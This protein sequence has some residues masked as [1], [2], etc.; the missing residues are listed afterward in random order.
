MKRLTD[1]IKGIFGSGAEVTKDIKITNLV[2]IEKYDAG[3]NGN[4]LVSQDDDL[5]IAYAERSKGLIFDKAP[6]TVKPD[7][8]T[9]YI[10]PNDQ[11]AMKFLKQHCDKTTYAVMEICPMII[12]VSKAFMRK[13]PFE[14][15]T[16]LAAQNTKSLASNNVKVMEQTTVAEYTGAAAEHWKSTVR[17]CLNKRD[18]KLN[19]QCLNYAMAVKKEL[20]KNNNYNGYDLNGIETVQNQ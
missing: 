11:V 9:A 17:Y 14:K 20:K 5:F 7:I 8:C 15:L 4:L 2:N 16:L 19:K 12:V 6:V 3:K 1:S 18:T 10:D 13:M